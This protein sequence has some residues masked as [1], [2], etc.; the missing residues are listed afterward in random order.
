[1]LGYPGGGNLTIG[2]AAVLQSYQ[3]R[4]RD[5]YN[6]NL[7][8]RDIYVL[9]ASVRPGSS[10]GP[11]VTPDG[12]VAG[13]VFARSISDGN[14]GYALRASELADDVLK[15]QTLQDAVSTGACAAD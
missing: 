10:G 14:V 13:L 3:A 8:T 1:M 11:F 6:H 2:P 4:G 9:Q 12:R 5:I 15:A 7:T